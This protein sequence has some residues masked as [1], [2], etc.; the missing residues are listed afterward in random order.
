MRVI[1]ASKSPRRE[2]LLKEYLPNFEIIVSDYEETD[3]YSDP[4]KTA[5]EYSIGKAKSVFDGLEDKSNVV[6]IG[7]DTV[8][9]SDGKILG[10]AKDKEQAK[11]MLK[12]LSNK[13]HKVISG[14]SIITESKT[15]NGYDL[16]LVTFNDL[17]S[18]DIDKYIGSGNYVGKAGAYGIQDGF[19]LVKEYKGSLNN[20]IGFP[21]EKIFKIL[22]EIL[23]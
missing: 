20:V 11:S 17:S 6:V 21:T 12:S 7:S 22:D 8:V 4:I 3:C 23:K 18:S 9:Y 10:K 14:Y 16:T 2:Q 5:I 13:T 15:F 1:L 19:N